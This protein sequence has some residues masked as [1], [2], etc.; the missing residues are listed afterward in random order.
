M[1]APLPKSSAPA[2]NGLSVP[3]PVPNIPP[4]LAAESEPPNR[5][6]VAN[7][8]P[9]AGAAP[10]ADDVGV[11]VWAPKENADLGCAEAAD[12]KM[13]LPEGAAAGP[14]NRLPPEGVFGCD[15]C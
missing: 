7:P 11:P 13:L 1:G 2:A 3:L 9:L 15:G 8:D 6:P 12:P 4:A 10:N 5:L 14:P